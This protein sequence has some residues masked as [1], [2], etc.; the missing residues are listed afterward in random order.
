MSWF[1]PRGPIPASWRDDRGTVLIAVLIIGAM[2]STLTVVALRSSA[3][4]ARAAAV[5]QDEMA[6]EDLG[7]AG[8]DLVAF[9]ILSR[10]GE[11]IRASSFEARLATGVI[12]VDYTSE[13]ARIDLNGA[14]PVLLIALF[15]SVGAQPALARRLAD[16]VVDFR[17]EDD[18][19]STEG[20]EAE[21]YRFAGRPPPANR[22]FGHPAELEQVLDITPSIAAA[23]RAL[24]TTANMSPT[25]DPTIA[26]P[27][28]IDVLMGGDANRTA[29]FIRR[30]ERGFAKDTDITEAFPSAM[31]DS[32]AVSPGKGYRAII[33][34]VVRGRFERRYEAVVMPGVGGA[35]DTRIVSW[36]SYP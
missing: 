11:P 7:R 28:V 8:A 26:S 24:V 21:D 3:S 19:K 36:D 33:K 32:I 16:Q 34:V 30:R 23:V 29:A 27:A 2:I 12:R 9:D 25:V 20:A 6:A 4:G 14:S 13:S 15:Q 35:Q 5:Y 10:A 1:T 17:D 18:D 22:P 31:R